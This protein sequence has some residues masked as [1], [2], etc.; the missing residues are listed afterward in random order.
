[1]RTRTSS[2][3]RRGDAAE[4]CVALIDRAAGED[5]VTIY[6]NDNHGTGSPAA[7]SWSSGAGRRAAGLVEPMLPA[8]RGPVLA[9]TR[10][11]IFYATPL[12]YILAQ[13][14]VEPDR[15]RR[16]GDRAVHPLLGARRLHPPHRGGGAARRGRPHLRGPRRGVAEDDG[17]Q[18]ARR[19]VDAGECRWG[20]RTNI[21]P[22]SWPR[23]PSS[24]LRSSPS[25][26]RSAR[27]SCATPSTPCSRSSATCSG[28]R[29]CSCC[30]AP[31]SSPRRR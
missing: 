26:G 22:R 27:S 25:P 5:V 4:R 9:K 14:E 10:H 3:E 17:A 2:R 8:R 20:C 29:R 15:A 13:E 16:A 28:W 12:E 21:A 23:S 24:S 19:G 31:S 11:S 30:C 1:M 7:S 18:H 6:V